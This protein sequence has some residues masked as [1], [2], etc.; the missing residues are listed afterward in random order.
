MS[1]KL[2]MGK[3]I[4]KQQNGCSLVSMHVCSGKAGLRKLYCTDTYPFLFVSWTIRSEYVHVC[5]IKVQ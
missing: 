5:I 1:V 4:Q 3:L 2:Y